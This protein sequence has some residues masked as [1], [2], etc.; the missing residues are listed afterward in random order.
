MA[1]IMTFTSIEAALKAGFSIY[2]RT[3]TEILVRI[4][5]DGGWALAIVVN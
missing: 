1:G 2:D 5:T 3:S 4:K